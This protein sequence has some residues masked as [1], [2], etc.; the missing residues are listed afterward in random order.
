VRVI[1]A[2]PSGNVGAQVVV[3]GTSTPVN[4]RPNPQI[5]DL[6]RAPL[7]PV[8]EKR[9]YVP[10]GVSGHDEPTPTPTPRGQARVQ[11]V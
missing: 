5:L 11:T 3:D 9:M 1:E 6:L 8:N 4:P 7:G 2:R 10:A